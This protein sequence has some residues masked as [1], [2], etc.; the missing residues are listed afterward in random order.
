MGKIFNYNGVVESSYD[1]R[2]YKIKADSEFPE[3]FELPKKVNV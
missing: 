1:A 3:T 2:D